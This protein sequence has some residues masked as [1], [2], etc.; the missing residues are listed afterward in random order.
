MGIKR[1]IICDICK[2]E[3]DYDNVYRKKWFIENILHSI[4][5]ERCFIN[6]TKKKIKKL[7]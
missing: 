6:S 5:T 1:V 2:K 7:L 4:C 3:E